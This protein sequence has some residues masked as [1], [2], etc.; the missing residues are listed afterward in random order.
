MKV[1]ILGDTH[2]GG[3]Y[4][5]GRI[6]SNRQLNT[7]LVD[8]SNTFDYVIDHMIG[9]GVKHFVITGDIFE[10]RRP[11]AS[12]LS[13]FSEKIYRLSELG[14]HTHIL[15]GNHDL[16]QEQRATTIDVLRCLKLPKVHVYAD[17]NSV[18]CDDG[19][20]SEI[21]NIIFFPF[22]TRRML[23]CK[24][25]DEAVKRLHDRLQYEIPGIS[26]GP[27]ILV[28]HFMLQGTMLGNTVLEGHGG[29]VV[30][31]QSMFKGLDGVIMGHIH[32]HQIVRKNN[33]LITYIGSMERKDFG[34]AKYPKY[35]LS[36]DVNESDVLFRFEKL[37]VR[38]V[39]DITIDQSLVKD[40]SKVTGGCIKFLKDHAR[41][42]EMFGSIVR[43]NIFINEK[44]L[45]DLD[46]DRIRSF[47]KEELKIHNCVNI[48]TQIVTKR[49]LRKASITE[50]IDPLKSFTEYLDLVEDPLMKE[51][52]KQVGSK[53]IKDRRIT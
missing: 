22:R 31:P 35:F 11:Q 2:F 44:A 32:P 47:L 18:A 53:I 51:K 6:D 15:I 29:E 46:K 3:G 12:E 48:H 36:V 38:P 40:G 13:L 45:Y 14:I 16:I 24:T 37:P 49:Q 30:L 23:D 9:D 4:S 25:N 52:M 27:K 26:K 34:D 10:Y 28:G 50:R 5:L 8:F 41:N 19:N 21:I 43:I 42:N 33:P 7:R 39:Y 17:I 1:V 20:S